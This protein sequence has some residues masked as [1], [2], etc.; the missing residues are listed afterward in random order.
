M[1]LLILVSVPGVR[2]LRKLVLFPASYFQ[3]RPPAETLLFAAGLV[4]A[5]TVV[6][7]GAI[8]LLGWLLAGTLDAT[9]TMENPDRPPDW[10]CERHGD[11]PDSPLGS[12]CDEPK[13]V[14]R[15][16]GELLFDATTDLAGYALVAP[17]LMWM[18]GAVV[19]YVAGRLAAGSP[20]FR[21]TLAL[22]GWAVLPEFLRLGIA[23]V[24]VYTALADITITDHEQAV[25]V[26]EPALASLEPYLVGVSLLTVVCQWALLTGGLVHDA[27][28]PWRTAAVAVA[29]PLGL[30]F[31]LS[32][33]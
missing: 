33:G 12:G 21:G 20:S 24:L 27:E 29:V 10:V 5:Y 14:E 3:D 25:D 6:L 4:V 23:L 11:D 32:A 1:Y 18:I 26:I 31:L 30:F 28:I 2:A 9:V 19:L 7:V 16:A 8:W 22:S 15:D 13:E 17:F